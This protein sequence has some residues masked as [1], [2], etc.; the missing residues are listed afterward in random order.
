MQAP[1]TPGVHWPERSVVT[2]T[3]PEERLDSEKEKEGSPTP[4]A[5]LII[6]IVQAKHHPG[7]RGIRHSTAEIEPVP[8]TLLAEPHS[9]PTMNYSHSSVGGG[10]G[11][12]C[13]NDSGMSGSGS[14][15][16]GALV[17]ARA[18]LPPSNDD[19]GASADGRYSAATTTA[20]AD[21]DA[22][23]ERRLESEIEVGNPDF[24][25]IVLLEGLFDPDTPVR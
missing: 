20:T 15:G 6:C 23:S 18:E 21:D 19:V 2:W 24:D 1:A 12:G 13:D 3:K 16:G 7:E 22:D 5:R 10:G 11:V 9:A 4:L 8:P 25:D 14:G 17:A